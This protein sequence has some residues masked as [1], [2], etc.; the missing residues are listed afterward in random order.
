METLKKKK[1]KKDQDESVK[2]IH[3]MFLWEGKNTLDSLSDNLPEF[4]I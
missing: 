3:E 1:K 2:H 4:E